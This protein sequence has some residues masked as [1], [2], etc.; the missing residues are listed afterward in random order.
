MTA[1]LAGKV[2]LVT[3]GSRGIGR[4]IALR[5]AR[6]GATVAIHYGHRRSAADETLGEIMGAGGTGFMI[7]A[8]LADPDAP[9]A[10]ASA[11]DAHADGIDIL[12]NNAG[13]GSMT[14]MADTDEAAFD[15]QMA[16]N[17]RAPFFI[18][19]AL[20]PRL[21]TG[22]RI[23]NISSMVTQAAYP[24]C[25][26]YAM[27]KAALNAMTL[28]LATELGPRGITVN[29]VAP[30]ATDTELTGPLLSDP[31]TVTALENSAALGRIG[32][33]ED[34]AD[35]VAFLAS[36][37]ARWVTGQLIEASGGTHL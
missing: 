22:G 23:I 18:T 36:D 24:G 27:S 35:V 17:A 10:I 8:D 30:G 28:S 12:V 6:D 33:P 37:D 21:R 31:A 26:A 2:A 19:R 34:I 20:L 16:V 7:E 13:I 25:L 15:S 5:L 3:G 14:G 11:L 32:K 9:A 29:G 4:A 1:R